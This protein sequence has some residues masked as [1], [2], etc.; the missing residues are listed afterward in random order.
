MSEGPS[1]LNP[2]AAGRH[3]PALDGLRALAV[4]VVLAFHGWP[5]AVPGGWLGVS[6]FFTLSGYLIVSLVLRDLQTDSFDLTAFFSKRLRRLMPASLA[7]VGAVLAVAALTDRVEVSDVVGDALAAFLH[8]ANWREASSSGGYEAIFESDARPLAHFWSLAIEEQFYLIVPPLLALVRKPALVLGVLAAGCAVGIGLWWGSPDAYYATPVRMGEILVGG[9]LATV[10]VNRRFRVPGAVAAMAA[11][12]GVAAVLTFDPAS[13][14]TSRGLP[15]LAAGLW[16]AIIAWATDHGTNPVLG[17]KPLRWVGERSYGIYLIHWPLLELTDLPVVAV[18]GLTFVIAELSHHL[19]ERPVRTGAVVAR[20]LVVLPALSV[21][22]ALV[23]ASVLLSERTVDHEARADAA[24]E[25][26]EWYREQEERLGVGHPDLAPVV[27]LFGDS[28]GA[29][30]A[31]G[32]RDWADENQEV[33]LIGAAVAGCASWGEEPLGWQSRFETVDGPQWESP[34]GCG[35]TVDGVVVRTGLSP[36]LVIHMDY[37]G[38]T[39]YTA[40]PVGSNGP[41][42]GLNSPEG[43]DAMRSVFTERLAQAA[44]QDAL[45]L[46]SEAARPTPGSAS[47]GLIPQY[48]S[49]LTAHA[50]LLDE[51]TDEPLVQ[52]LEIAAAL[53]QQPDR[54]RR[55][56]GTHLDL[57]TASDLFAHEVLGPQILEALRSAPRLAATND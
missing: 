35:E 55:S 24:R 47:D 11:V 38:A 4:L 12:L 25:V 16:M 33:V 39:L 6:L 37:G 20:P 17:W 10:T 26:P 3:L 15:I 2:V 19:L 44:T 7:V 45:T 32:A 42:V 40:R 31:L 23:C 1:P 52:R 50:E 46:V 43:L 8:F 13:A 41:W 9:W 28:T 18:F 29:S 53:S 22:G 48:E 5:D 57:G 56:D 36:D 51:L 34:L 27:F 30:V 21:I 49:K 14:A 54:Y